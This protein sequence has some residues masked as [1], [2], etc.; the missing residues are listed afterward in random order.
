[1]H[2]FVKNR[3]LVVLG[4]LAISACSGKKRDFADGYIQGTEGADDAGALA[5]A[6]PADAPGRLQVRPEAV[7][8]GWV[9]V[10]FPARARVQIQNAG[11]ALIA[12]PAVEWSSNVNGDFELIQNQCLTE[13]AP[14]AVCELRVQLI[15]KLAGASSAALSVQSS[16]GA[17]D[18]SFTGLGLAG[19]DLIIAPL[20][21]SFE[22]FGGVLVGAA[23]EGVFSLTNPTAVPTGIV[24]MRTNRADFEV[25]PPA[26]DGTDCVLG[27]TSLM[28]GQSCNVRVAFRPLERGPLEATLT[29]RTDEAGAASATLSGQGLL[30]GVLAASAES[31]D[32]DGVVVGTGAQ[33][34]IA[35]ENQGDAPITLGKTS[36]EPAGTEGFSILN[37][38]CG[39][40]SALAGGAACSVQLEFRPLRADE[41]VTTELISLDSAGQR[42]LGVALRGIGLEPG[43]LVL[44]AAASGE[45][46]FGQVLLDASA[47]HT[48]TITNPGMQPSG[49]LTFTTSDGFEVLAAALEGECVP[50]V[51]SLVDGQSCTVRVGFTPVRREVQHGS[52][53]VSSELA[54]ANSLALTGQGVIQ[55]TFEVE[56]ELNFGRVFTNAPTSRPLSIK[57]AGDLPLAPPSL[58]IESSSADLAG[59]FAVEGACVTPLAF[60]EQCDIS[61]RF[62]PALAVPHSANLLLRSEPGAAATVLL[63][64]EALTPGSLVLAAQGGSPDF[65]DVPVQTT[66]TRN[67]TLTNPGNAPSGL[68]TLRSDS[69]RFVVSNG[70]CNRGDAAG[71]V[72]GSRCTFSV[73]F[74]PNNSLQLVANLSVQSLGAGQAGLELRGR[75]RAL[76]TLTAIGNRNLGTANIGQNALTQPEN[77]FTWTVSNEGDLSTGVLAVTNSNSNEFEKTNDSCNNSQIAPRS[78]CQMTLRFR[79]NDVN[80]RTSTVVVSDATNQRSATLQLTGTGVRLAQLGQSCVNATCAQGTCTGGVCCDRE[81]D[82][83]CQACSTSGVCV[84]Q[85]NR[86]RCGNGNGRC[87]GVD[88]CLLPEGLACGQNGDCGLGNCERRLSGSGVNDRICCA[89]DC[90]ATGQQCNA[91]GQ[92]QQPTLGQGAVCGRAGDLP[93]GSNLQCKSCNDGASRCTQPGNCCSDSECS[94]CERCNQGA[95]GALGAGQP[96]RCPGNQVCDTQRRCVDP[97][98]G[99]GESCGSRAECASGFCADGVCCQSQC[100]GVC[101]G[102]CEAGTGRCVPLPARTPCGAQE[103]A[104]SFCSAGVAGCFVAPLC[105]GAGVCAQPT[106]SCNGNPN[107]SVDA[108]A[109]C[110]VPM[111]PGLTLTSEVFRSD[112][113]GSNVGVGS[114]V[115]FCDNQNDCPANNFCCLSD[116]GPATQARSVACSAFCSEFGDSASGIFIVCRSPGGGTSPCPGNRACNRTNIDLPGWM[117]CAFP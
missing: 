30:A 111:P 37:S 12:A 31:V 65:G 33:R 41:E 26:G 82:G 24:D 34:T 89:T 20:E 71:L 106:V 74:T 78:S 14:G 15:P 16:V 46:D 62:A 117:F 60:G 53:T 72:D 13:L 93:C 115:A 92:C 113:E 10:G 40:G 108:N 48:F 32:F 100:D 5:T 42:R 52:L 51:T 6:S 55:A 81:C 83:S 66:V 38:D 103:P 4:L 79:P 23:A 102:S 109:C 110:E 107:T 59:A 104:I 63:L 70:D 64:A 9:T 47:V 61:V 21:G 22:D 97:L 44:N 56:P 99:L 1:M 98:R 73:A 35:L 101:E 17:G 45:E 43:S 19:G 11:S 54:G 114:L 112:C 49:V 85:T 50:G 77:Q 90:D 39:E 36:L 8:L 75:G 80:T 28:S 105:N 116:Q 76:P 88:R 3:R 68:L 27:V 2:N 57:N 25:L 58:T 87:F 84:D 67:F 86:E 96:D 7:D 69:S 91:Q 18:V 95:C 29:T 94:A